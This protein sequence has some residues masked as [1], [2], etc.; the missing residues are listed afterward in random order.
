MLAI[1][2]SP[3]LKVRKN[4]VTLLPSPTISILEKE[5]SNCLIA[6]GQ[7]CQ[8]SCSESR[9]AKLGTLEPKHAAWSQNSIDLG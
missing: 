8:R 4:P 2:F 9:A 3:T 5:V 7:K 1:V 6:H